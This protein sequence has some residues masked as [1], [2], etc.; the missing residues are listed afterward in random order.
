MEDNEIRLVLKLPCR[1]NE[2]NKQEMG[3]L[4]CKATVY[5]QITRFHKTPLYQIEG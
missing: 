2:V 5:Q 4:P 3:R 1:V